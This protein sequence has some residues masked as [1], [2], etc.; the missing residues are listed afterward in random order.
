MGR[1]RLE[2]DCDC[3]GCG[4]PLMAGEVA[5][6]EGDSVGCCQPCLKDATASNLDRSDVRAYRAAFDAAPVT[7]PVKRCG[8]CAACGAIVPNTWTSPYLAVSAG[9][10]VFCDQDCYESKPFELVPTPRGKPAPERFENNR[11][12]DGSKMPQMVLFSGSRT[13]ITGQADLFE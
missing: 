11:R 10:A 2:T 3:G 13:C 8:K 5:W 7:G 6:R 4:S 9:G 12:A 1:I